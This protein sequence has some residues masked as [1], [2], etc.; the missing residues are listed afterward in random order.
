[1]NLHNVE[2]KKLL[3]KSRR[4]SVRYRTLRVSIERLSLFERCYRFVN[5]GEHDT[6]GPWIYG[7]QMAK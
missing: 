2:I 3:S 6:P 5:C 7:C 4:E 1:M